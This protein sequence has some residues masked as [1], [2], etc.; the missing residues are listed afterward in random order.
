LCFSLDFGFALSRLTGGG[1]PIAS[2]AAA[3]T[4]FIAR[5]GF[6]FLFFAT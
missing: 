2:R 5:N 3:F 6:G 4:A 1:I